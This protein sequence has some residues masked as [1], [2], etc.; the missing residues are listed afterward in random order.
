MAIT[1]RD[2]EKELA[3]APAGTKDMGGWTR[4]V[5]TADQQ[6]RLGVTEDGL[7]VGGSL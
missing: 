2:L 5:F 3:E 7:D 6:A 1:V 4:A